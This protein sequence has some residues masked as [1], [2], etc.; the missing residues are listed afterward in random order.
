ME[1]VG[2]KTVRAAQAVVS[3]QEGSSVPSQ[4]VAPVGTAHSALPALFPSSFHLL[5][6]TQ[7]VCEYVHTHFIRKKTKDQ[8]VGD[9]ARTPSLCPQRPKFFL[10]QLSQVPSSPESLTTGHSKGAQE[11]HTGLALGKD[12]EKVPSLHSPGRKALMSRLELHGLF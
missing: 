11:A 12:P 10:Y 9:R 7:P 5:C 4:A 1:A 2:A 6:P 8:N 3:R